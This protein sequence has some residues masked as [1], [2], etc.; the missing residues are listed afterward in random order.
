MKNGTVKVQCNCAHEFQDKEHG[1]NI[2]VANATKK[3]DQQRADVRCTVCSRI[4]T[5]SVDAIKN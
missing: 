4:H 1:K 3:Q 5:V 2:R